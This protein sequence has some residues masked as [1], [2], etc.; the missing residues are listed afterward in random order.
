MFI[1]GVQYDRTFSEKYA[2]VQAKCDR[3]QAACRLHT[4]VL[5]GAT[6]SIKP[7]NPTERGTLEGNAAFMQA[8]YDRNAGCMQPALPLSVPPA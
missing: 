2:R 7:C 3:M 8:A 4:I 1:L 5:R 6:P